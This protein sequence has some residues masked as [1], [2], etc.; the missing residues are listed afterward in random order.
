MDISIGQSFVSPLPWVTSPQRELY[1]VVA[2]SGNVPSLVNY[3]GSSMKRGFPEL[4]ETG[5]VGTASIPKKKKTRGK[6]RNKKS[7]K[8]PSCKY[9]NMYLMDRLQIGM[10]LKKTG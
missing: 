9:R 5:E 7:L 4:I 3:S 8:Q 6:N 1:K 2:I 10:P